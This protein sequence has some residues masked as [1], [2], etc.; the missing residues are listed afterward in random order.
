VLQDGQRPGWWLAGE[1]FL[2]RLMEPFD[3]AAGLRVVGPG[4][5][6]HDTA[7]VQ[8]EFE[9]DPAHAAVAAGEHRAV[10]GE[11]AG[12]IAV[13]GGGVAVGGGDVGGLEHGSGG[14]GQAE[15][16]VVVEDVQDLHIGA[17]GQAP[18]GD[19]G[20]PAF[21]G[22][23]GGEAGVGGF[24]PLVR[25]RGDEPAGGQDAPDRAHRGRLSL[26]A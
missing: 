24:G 12:R 18:V 22:L 5:G 13:A 3:L 16:G 26:V 20:L 9:R 17:A 14:A 19:V 2:Q 6:E 8:G 15:S 21:V 23:L 1:P 11:H 10:V 7:L 25:L 4:V